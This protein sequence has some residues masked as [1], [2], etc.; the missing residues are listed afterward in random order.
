MTGRI[1]VDSNIWIYLFAEEDKGKK[2]TAR[3]F[4]LEKARDNNFIISFQV[5][6]EVCKVLKKKNFPEE[7]LRFVINRL[8]K[9]CKIHKSKIEISLKAS[10]LREN[11]K[12]S[13]WDSHIVAHA[14]DAKCDILASEDMQ[15][16]CNIYGTIIKN[17]FIPT[18]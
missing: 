11:H 4:I 1:F 18:L 5:I 2:A 6:N 12:F 10:E 16:D 9:I 13:F 3:K 15:H 7:K 8:A 14:I 17:I